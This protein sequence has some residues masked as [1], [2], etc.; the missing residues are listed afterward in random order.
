MRNTQPELDYDAIR[1]SIAAT[2]VAKI[3][4]RAAIAARGQR[5]AYRHWNATTLRHG[6]R[7]PAHQAGDRRNGE[8]DNGHEK[9]QLGRLDGNARDTAEPTHGGDQ[10]RPQKQSDTSALP[11]INAD[12]EGTGSIAQEFMSV[13]V[14]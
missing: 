3:Q 9:H 11:H 14:A 1:L 4:P 10:Q 7:A 2:E 5:N 13:S 8:Q 6:R 12:I